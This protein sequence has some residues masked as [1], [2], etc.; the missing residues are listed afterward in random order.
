MGLAF[1]GIST[2]VCVCVWRGEGAVRDNTHTRASGRFERAVENRTNQIGLSRTEATRSEPLDG[3][4]SLPPPLLAG[5]R[6]GKGKQD[7]RGSLLISARMIMITI[8][9]QERL[10]MTPGKGRGGVGPRSQCSP[11]CAHFALR[12]NSGQCRRNA[13]RI[14][15]QTRAVRDKNKLRPRRRSFRAGICLPAALKSA[16]DESLV[17]RPI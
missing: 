14:H 5:T 7:A 3:G 16:R 9:I 11:L 17:S 6:L 1:G 15:T 8:N 4:G 13:A 12:V 2:C 10:R